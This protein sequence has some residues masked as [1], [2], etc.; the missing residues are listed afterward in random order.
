MVSAQQVSKELVVRNWSFGYWEG[1]DRIDAGLKELG[2]SPDQILQLIEATNELRDPDFRAA[3]FELLEI[4][5]RTGKTSQEAETYA[6]ELDSQIAAKEKQGLDWDGRIEKAKGELTDW[7]QKRNSEKLKFET[8]QAQNKRLLEEDREK[9]KAEREKFESEQAGNK[10]L[11]GEDN[12]KLN[13]ELSKNNEVRGNIEDTITLKAEVK[14]IGLDLPTFK[15]IV[16]EVV[17]A[18]MSPDTGNKVKEDVKKLGS[19]YK[20][21]AKREK[22]E[23]EKKEVLRGLA[24]RVAMM[25]RTIREQEGAVDWNKKLIEENKWQYEFFELFISMLLNSPS[26]RDTLT[27]LGLR[28]QA[29]GEKGWR[30]STEGTPE[31]RRAAFII[32]VMESYLHSIHCE[33]CG[34]SFIVD[35]PYNAYS[36][37][38][39]SYYCP[40]CFLSS[41]TKPDNAFFNL[42]VSPGLVKR[43]RA[44]RALLD[45]IE[46]M[47]EIFEKRVK[48]LDSLPNKVINALSE[49]RSIKARDYGTDSGEE[50]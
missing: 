15:S 31:K 38:R 13:R 11:L 7:E 35:Q 17:K 45:R 30:H 42:M 2:I 41:Y 25:R 27:A 32:S 34:T 18:R 29:L 46:K 24:D 20:A 36:R 47:D 3:A 33:N 16:R 22:E 10:R 14:R 43:L 19:L 40:V 44:A 48:L 8:E 37:Y 49:G 23:K 1:L 5:K 26:A 4:M 9:R 50:L 6:K 28:I 21:I 12:E 39:G